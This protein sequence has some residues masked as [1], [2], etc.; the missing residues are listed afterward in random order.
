M[1]K[2]AIIIFVSL[3]GIIAVIICIIVAILMIFDFF[4]SNASDG[5]VEGNEEYAGVY[6]EVLNK[7]IKYGNGYVPLERIL[8]FY[9]STDDETFDTIYSDNLDLENK[10]QKDLEEVCSLKKYSVLDVCSD[11]Q[12]EDSNLIGGDQ[13]KPFSSPLE[14]SNMN[15]TSFFME[16]RSVFNLF[17]IHHAWDL[18]S[19]NQTPV[20]SVCDG[21]VISVDYPYPYNLTDEDGGGGNQIKIRCEIDEDVV[22]DV[23]YA[24]LYPNSAVVKVGDQVTHWQ[25]IASI[26]TTGYSTGPHLHFQVEQSGKTIDGMSLIDFTIL[27]DD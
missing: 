20:Y 16:E 22:Y 2:K 13:I 21:D 19:P 17:N 27:K 10:R 23:L 24:H 25:Q 5:Y 14:I 6:K 15:V 9:K 11:E 3:A 18:S 26:G 12:I 4:G 1:K 7:N 8:Y